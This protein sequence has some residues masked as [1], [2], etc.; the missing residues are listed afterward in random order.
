MKKFNTDREFLQEIEAWLCFNSNPS[1][2]Q[3][4]ELKHTLQNHLSIPI[5][6]PVMPKITDVIEEC[7]K[8]AETYEPDEKLDYVT[9]ASRD[10][11]KLKKV[12]LPLK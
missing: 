8:I 2:D 1:Q 9:Y 4:L 3:I 11:R 5:E 12:Y 7:A 6:P 10:I